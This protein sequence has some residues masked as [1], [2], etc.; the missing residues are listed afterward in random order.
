MV[1]TS[2][3]YRTRTICESRTVFFEARLTAASRAQ[4]IVLTKLLAIQQI[5]CAI[6]FSMGGQQVR[7][8]RICT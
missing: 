1:L 3:P 5:L 4:Y 7:N 6:G 2:L 8:E